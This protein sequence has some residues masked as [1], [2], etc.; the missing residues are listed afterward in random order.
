MDTNKMLRYSI[1]LSMLKQL[2]LKK[3]INEEEYKSIEKKLMNDY[4]VISNITT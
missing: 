4:A 2:Y 3:L 1:Q